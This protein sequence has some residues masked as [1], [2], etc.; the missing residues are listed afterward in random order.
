[1]LTNGLVLVAGGLDNGV[2][3]LYNPVTQTWALTGSLN[4]A[5]GYATLTVLSNGLVLAAGGEGS[6]GDVLAS[7]ELYNPAP[8][9]W[10]EIG[11]LNTAREFHT[12]TLLPDGEVLV[13]GGFNNGGSISTA[14]LLNLSTG[15]WTLTGSL[16][17]SRGFHTAT[18]LPNGLVVAI[19]GDNYPAGPLA[20]AEL[21][22]PASGTWETIV[23]LNTARFDHTANLLPNGNV[24]VAGGYGSGGFGDPLSSA[25]LF[26][27]SGPMIT[28][29]AGNYVL[30]GD[31]T[32]AYSG[33]GGPATDA[34]LDYP[35]DVK[36]D[37]SG[38]L[39][40]ADT[41]NN[42][43]RQVDGSGTITTVVGDYIQPG[44]YSGDGGVPTEA[45][46]NAPY[47]VALDVWG[48]VFIA[49]SYNNVIR[50]VTNY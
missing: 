8:G 19:G 12:A 48:D 25:E 17:T 36:V 47:G 6:G 9:T 18:L 27:P 32:G 2:A 29:V 34:C 42:V 4:E 44:T 28:T 37:S 41:Y 24:L 15:A 33:D 43:I 7:A 45:G 26:V 35:C 46:L 23:S 31:G 38:D 30:S 13:A 3:E 16:N 14:E 1:M 50:K 22:H 10:A 39:F 49:D 21:Y 40:I 11:S 5:R 20:G